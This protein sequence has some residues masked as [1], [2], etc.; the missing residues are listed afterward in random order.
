MGK[1]FDLIVFD[2]DGTLM[3]STAFIVDALQAACL[4]MG[5]PV[6]ERSEA[7]HVIG[8]GLAE[9][10]AYLAPE[11][12]AAGGQQLAARYRY[13]YLAHDD[14]QTPFAGVEAMLG[15][16]RDAGFALAIATGKARRGLDRALDQCGLRRYFDATR[17]ADESFSKPHPGMLLELM[18][19]FG[20]E[21][22][23]LL[24]VGDTTHDIQMAQNASAPAVAVSYG[25]HPREA[26]LA[27]G[28]LALVDSVPQLM[29][30][31]ACNA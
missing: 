30:W 31:L 5:L 29:E 15:G 19:E 26:L 11:L 3:D 4:D 25:A 23:R 2:W 22:S 9:A 27:T 6:P 21:A 18:D 13:H 24:M 17:C 1:R 7:A 16:L 10:V 8:L 28:P 12:D 14:K 20:L